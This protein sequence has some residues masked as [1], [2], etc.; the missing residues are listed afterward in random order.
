MYKELAAKPN[1]EYIAGG[2]TQNSIRVAQ[3]MLQVPGATS[4]M[5][6]IGKDEF[7]EAMTATAAK[8]GVNVRYM[9]DPSV[10]TGTCAVCIVDGERSLVANLAAANNFKVIQI[11]ESHNG[12]SQ[13]SG[14]CRSRPEWHMQ[15][16]AQPSPASV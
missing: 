9:V 15:S 16:T 10:S 3:W 8:D 4:Y 2:A 12:G 6:C 1:V 7:G 13:I 14:C 5:G 11:D